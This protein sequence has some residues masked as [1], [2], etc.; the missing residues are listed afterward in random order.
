MLIS[1]Y[2]HKPMDDQRIMPYNKVAA[3]PDYPSMQLCT[4]SPAP[5]P[6]IARSAL[7]NGRTVARGKVGRWGRQARG[8]GASGPR[9]PVT[10]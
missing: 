6:V 4:A 5:S 3:M 10:V 7:F 9:W 1:S 2:R 8:V